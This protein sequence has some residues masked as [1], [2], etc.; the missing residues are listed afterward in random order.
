MRNL[1]IVVKEIEIKF[2]FL[3]QEGY[4]FTPVRIFNE[5]DKSRIFARLGLINHTNGRELNFTILPREIFRI[6]VFITNTTIDESLDIKH[7]M[8]FKDGDPLK[9]SPPF[10]IDENNLIVSTHHVLSKVKNVIQT[11][12]KDVVMNKEWITIP[13]YDPK[14]NY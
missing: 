9:Y 10:V 3:N 11:D 13:T 4:S 7:Y 14:D 1:D 8:E 6:E 5:D 12:L 2:N